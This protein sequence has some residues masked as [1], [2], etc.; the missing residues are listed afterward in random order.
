MT[1]S[2]SVSSRDADVGQALGGEVAQR[3]VR[4]S[5]FSASGRFDAACTDQDA[6]EEDTRTRS[7]SSH[8]WA[9]TPKIVSGECRANGRLRRGALGRAVRI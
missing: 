1:K 2:G 3:R 8:F 6:E 9:Q 5:V 7:E 4:A